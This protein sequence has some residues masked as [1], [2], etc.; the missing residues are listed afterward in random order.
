[1]LQHGLAD[2]V[3]I[4]PTTFTGMG[5][6]EGSTIG[7][8]EQSLEQCGRVGPRARRTLARAFGQNGMH[9]VPDILPNYC[10]MLTRITR[11]FMHSLADIDA[12]VQHPVDELLVHLV[13]TRGA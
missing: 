10:L 3:A 13:A 12:V 9:L 7:A 4:E 11:T 1:M 2:I 8:I 5:W 6:R